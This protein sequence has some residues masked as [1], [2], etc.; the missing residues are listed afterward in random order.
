MGFVIEQS[1]D[2]LVTYC[3]DAP[4][5]VRCASI[6]ILTKEVVGIIIAAL[7][8]LPEGLAAVKAARADRLQTSLNL[9]LGSFPGCPRSDGR[10]RDF[11]SRSAQGA[12]RRTSSSSHDV[13]RTA[14]LL[15]S[16]RGESMFRSDQELTSHQKS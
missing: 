9:A 16:R 13:P 6:S 2:P 4:Q 10:K 15:G 8:L 7:V 14:L 1:L 11:P 5:R 3:D 12:V